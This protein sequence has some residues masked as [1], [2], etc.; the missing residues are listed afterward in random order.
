MP[1]Y[2]RNDSKQINTDEILMLIDPEKAVPI[3]YIKTEADLFNSYEVDVR[4]MRP[5][6]PAAWI[7]PLVEHMELYNV[8]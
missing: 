3:L 4:G 7:D 8:E 6:N 1:I 2:V 5:Y